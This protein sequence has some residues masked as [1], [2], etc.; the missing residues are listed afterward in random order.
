[1]CKTITK[2]LHYKMLYIIRISQFTAL[3][4]KPIKSICLYFSKMY[5]FFSTENNIFI[6]SYQ[7]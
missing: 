7:F 2:I 1:M 3:N 6:K 4:L 5:F